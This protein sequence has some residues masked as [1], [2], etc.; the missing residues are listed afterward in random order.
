MA[1]SQFHTDTSVSYFSTH[2][3][4]Y[5][6]Y[7]TYSVSSDR[8]IYRTFLPTQGV[9]QC[10]FVVPMHEQCFH[11]IV[12]HVCSY[13]VRGEPFLVAF[14]L[15]KTLQFLKRMEIRVH[16]YYCHSALT[17]S[18]E[19]TLYIMSGPIQALLLC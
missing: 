7:R 19:S 16:Y 12:T 9:V 15:K 17:G 14:G 10:S 11:S 18:T 8:Q 6:D 2:S 1:F 5:A 13:S 4:D 3:Q